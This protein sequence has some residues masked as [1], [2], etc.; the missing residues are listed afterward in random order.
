MHTPIGMMCKPSKWPNASFPGIIP[1]SPAD[2]PHQYLLVVKLITKSKYGTN[3]VAKLQFII[4]K[5]C[6]I[7]FITSQACNIKR[8]LCKSMVTGHESGAMK[9]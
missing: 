9:G 3:H 6:M 4:P 1:V 2:I 5:L 8:P 7:R